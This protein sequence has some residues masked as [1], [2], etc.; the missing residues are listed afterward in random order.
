MITETPVGPI[1]TP[2]IV[3]PSLLFKN[4]AASVRSWS[5]P[6]SVIVGRSYWMCSVNVS[7]PMSMC[8]TSGLTGSRAGVKRIKGV[9]GQPPPEVD[10]AGTAGAYGLRLDG[11]SG[12]ERLLSPVAADAPLLRVE[13]VVGVGSILD[14]VLWNDRAQFRLLEAEATALEI[15]RA[16]LVAR[17]TV[18]QPFDDQALVHPYLALPAA[19]VSHWA[20]TDAFHAGAFVT[21]RGAWALLGDKG[22]GKSSTLAYLAARGVGV[23]SDDLLIVDHGEVLAG[24]NSIDLRPGAAAHLGIG[25][26]L[27]V[28]GARERWRVVTAPSAPRTPLCGWIFLSWGDEVSLRPVPVSRRLSLLLANPALGL[29]RTQPKRLLELAALPGWELRRPQRWEVMEE[30]LA[31]LDQLGDHR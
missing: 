28:V 6:I 21:D 14:S 5:V 18:K 26:Y 29:P 3:S 15:S 22:L 4:F 10:G 9:E 8:E 2:P 27:G 12:A 20:G 25:E 17:F 30:V 7:P 23:L 24:P 11:L 1:G 13:Q 16:P 19:T 31:A